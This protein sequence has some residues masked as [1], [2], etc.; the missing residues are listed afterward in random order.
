MPDLRAK[1]QA[2]RVLVTRP[3][4][5]NTE[6]CQLLDAQGWHAVSFPLLSFCHQTPKASPAM[7]PPNVIIAISPRAVQFGTAWLKE[8]WPELLHNRNSHQTTPQEN[9]QWIAI[10]PATKEALHQAGICAQNTPSKDQTSEDLLNTSFFKTLAP[11]QTIWLL[12]GVGGR[13]IIQRTLTNQGHKVVCFDVYKRRLPSYTVSQLQAIR[14]CSLDCLTVSS[15]E[16]LHALFRLLSTEAAMSASNTSTALDSTEKDRQDKKQQS[17]TLR[18]ESARNR[19]KSWL[20]TTLVVVGQRQ[21]E[22]AKQLGF[23]H[24]VISP[25]AD[26]DTLAQTLNQWRATKL[27]QAP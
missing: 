6:L 21:A 18:L 19:P 15:T 13:E 1:H 4:P 8:K 16:I 12:K 22:D 26:N 14:E 27:D 25:S 24:I 11:C 2:L 17:I 23:K 7:Q 9:P 10:G 20:S 3:E 5:E